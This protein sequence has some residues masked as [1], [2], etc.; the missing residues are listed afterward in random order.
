MR[1]VAEEL[2]VSLSR[3]KAWEEGRLN[4]P[5]L[6]T[7]A[8]QTKIAQQPRIKGR[9]VR[10]LR[11]F[12]G[13]T[14][15]G[16]ARTIGITQPGLSYWEGRDKPITRQIREKIEAAFGAKIAEL[17]SRVGPHPAASVAANAG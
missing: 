15:V 9:D 14:Q 5:T 11:E 10:R 2:Q 8:L 17:M 13:L 3:A 16:F 6:A 12:L 7:A 1:E 4:V